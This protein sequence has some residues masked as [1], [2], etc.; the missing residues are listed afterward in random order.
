MIAPPSPIRDV[1][2]DELI[3][4]FDTSFSS[5]PPAYWL[6]S[7]TSVDSPIKVQLSISMS[8]LSINIQLFDT[9]KLESEIVS[10]LKAFVT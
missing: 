10:V 5:I 8:V 3:T 6:S 2:E 9:L 1:K 4:P 7:L